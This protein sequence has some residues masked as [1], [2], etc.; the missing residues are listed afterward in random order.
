LTAIIALLV[1]ADGAL[2]T[3]LAFSGRTHVVQIRLEV[4]PNDPRVTSLFNA[5]DSSG[6][7]A[8]L[9]SLERRASSDSLVLR[10][11][12]QLAHA[13]GRR[14]LLRSDGGAEV[15]KSCRPVFASGC[16]H[17][18]VEALLNL[19]GRVEMPALQ[20]M[21]F[22]AGGA[23]APGPVYECVHGLGHGLLG[24]VAMDVGKALRHCDELQ[25]RSFVASCHEGVF[26]EAIDSAFRRPSEHGRH[27]HPSAHHSH[28]TEVALQPS[29]PYSPCD[30]YSD[31]YGRSC[32]LF[33]GF[34]IL[35]TV[36]FE[37][38]PALSLCS[39]APGGRAERC[40][41]SVGHQLAGLFQRGDAWI[42]DQ[43]GKGR[44]E[45]A[46]SCA[47]G[48]ALALAALDWSGR[49]VVGFCSAVPHAWTGACRRAA[50][51]MLAQVAPA[52]QR[53]SSC[54]L[55]GQENTQD[56]HSIDEPRRVS[57]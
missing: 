35:R 19:W 32:W 31:P 20:G 2:L 51:E 5:L 1:V 36:S 9:D 54:R 34:V 43:C 44:A 13:L 53:L 28:S 24:A 40:Y 33:Q 38:G 41:E 8:A 48:A 42:I 29:D 17:G 45:Q 49:R 11:G 27:Q 14:A 37:P 26:M 25:G 55:L 56:C 18:V 16:Y 3:R 57:R 50:M 10:S 23:E 12:H 15:L 22:A 47:S 7:A 30:R 39:S 4:E 6:L 52:Q 46:A 21:C